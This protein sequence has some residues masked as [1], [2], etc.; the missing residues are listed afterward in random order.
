M[1]CYVLPD[2]HINVLV[3]YFIGRNTYSGLWCQMDEN[4]QYIRKENA[5]RLAQILY[6]ANVE[7]VNANYNENKPISYLGY[8][9]LPQVR[10]VYTVPEIALALNSFDYQSCEVKDYYNTEAA[11]I[12]NAM[13]K[14]LLTQLIEEV[15]PD[16]WTI[17][18]IKT[19]GV[20]YI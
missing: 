7:S 18:E 1:S 20:V 6:Q 2:E 10:D 15:D 3:N 11:R 9:Y 17:N 5:Q 13:R 8:E 4:Y 19:N 16:T 12:I 14:D